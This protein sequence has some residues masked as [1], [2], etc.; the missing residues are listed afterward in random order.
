MRSH[1][2]AR[3][4]ERPYRRSVIF[5]VAETPFFTRFSN[6]VD[7][8]S[9]PGCMFTGQVRQFAD[10]ALT[11]ERETFAR[12]VVEQ[13]EFDSEAPD[14]A[15]RGQRTRSINLSVRSNTLLLSVI[16]GLLLLAVAGGSPWLFRSWSRSA[17]VSSFA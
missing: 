7:K 11:I 14:T 3:S 9:M 1:A 16:S 6:E 4:T 12:M 10:E 5:W 13:E 17:T 8:A 2:T 15:A